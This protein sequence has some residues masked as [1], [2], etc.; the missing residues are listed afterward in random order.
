MGVAFGLQELIQQGKLRVHYVLAEQKG[1]YV[2]QS[3]ET[4]IITEDSFEQLT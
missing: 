3:E 4:I 1:A 2:A